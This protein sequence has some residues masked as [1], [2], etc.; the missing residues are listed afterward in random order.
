M[1]KTSVNSEYLAD[2]FFDKDQWREKFLGKKGSASYGCQDPKSFLKKYTPLKGRRKI[3]ICKFSI[4]SFFR[5]GW[6][7]QFR[8]TQAEVKEPSK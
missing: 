1:R 5:L 8:I 6:Q 3:I 2:G 4:H 7:Q